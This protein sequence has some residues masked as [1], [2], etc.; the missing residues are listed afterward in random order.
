M[1][2]AMACLTVGMWVFAL[3]ALPGFVHRDHAVVVHVAARSTRR[4]WVTFGRLLAC[5]A[6]ILSP[7]LAAAH[8][9]PTAVGATSNFAR[10]VA[11]VVGLG[12][13]IN[14]AAGARVRDLPRR[15]PGTP[16]QER[17]DKATSKRAD[18]SITTAASLAGGT[19][20]G[21]MKEHIE[22]A[23]P[24]GALVKAT[25]M[26]RKHVELYKEVGLVPL[27]TRPR[28]VVGQLPAKP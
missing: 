8:I 7:V 22:A 9:A 16:S 24:E 1:N 12:A 6:V 3:V 15:A 18:W 4:L 17:D 23:L 11:C 20:R 26:S 14:W 2:T 28:E 21:I 25:A 27:V 5:L 13:L 19:G 10:G